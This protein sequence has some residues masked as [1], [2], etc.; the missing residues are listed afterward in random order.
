MSK[1]TV[2]KLARQRTL[3]RNVRT[4]NGWRKSTTVLGYAPAVE[5]KAFC[6]PRN[7]NQFVFLSEGQIFNF[8]K[9]ARRGN[10]IYKVK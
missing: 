10:I 5:R 3:T 9:A 8:E 2:T 6:N 4:K 1:I 7:T